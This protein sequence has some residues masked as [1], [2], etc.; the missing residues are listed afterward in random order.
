MLSTDYYSKSAEVAQIRAQLFSKI[1]RDKLVQILG[2]YIKSSDLS[3]MLS[4]YSTTAQLGDSLVYSE[5]YS[6]EGIDKDLCET[7]FSQ[8]REIVLQHKIVEGT[9]NLVLPGSLNKIKVGTILSIK[10]HSESVHDLTIFTNITS[11]DTRVILSDTDATPIIP[12]ETRHYIILVDENDSTIPKYV[13]MNDLTRFYTK[14]E[15]DNS[16]YTKSE[17]DTSLGLKVDSSSLPDSLIYYSKYSSLNLLYDEYNLSRL[18]FSTKRQITIEFESNNSSHKVI[19]SN[20]KSM[21]SVGSILTIYNNSISDTYITLSSIDDS[22]NPT[23]IIIV[24]NSN[25]I[26]PGEIRHYLVTDA[27]QDFVSYVDLAGFSNNTTYVISSGINYDLSNVDLRKYS[28]IIMINNTNSAIDFKLPSTNDK[29]TPGTFIIVKAGLSSHDNLI[30]GSL[31]L[32]NNIFSESVL[33]YI[34][35]QE[36]GG[37]VQYL[38]V[39][40]HIVT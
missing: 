27:S 21:I 3:S 28:K 14:T 34:S 24:G 7:D 8:N 11:E 32:Y 10:N 40:N 36:S 6:L 12:G 4:D 2:D 16:F 9:C 22:L 35:Y 18:V 29:I 17:M 19:V 5:I 30:N 39:N 1:S 26:I 20:L 37:V 25:P 33:Q 15:V 13:N 31:Y 23:E 38:L